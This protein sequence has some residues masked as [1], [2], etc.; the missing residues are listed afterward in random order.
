LT[1]ERHQKEIAAG[2]RSE[3]SR[4]FYKWDAGLDV[5]NGLILE[6]RILFPASELRA[7]REA[8]DTDDSIFWIPAL[9]EDG[10]AVEVSLFTAPG[11]PFAEGQ[12]PAQRRMGTLVIGQGH[13]SDGRR[14]WL[15]FRYCQSP[16]LSKLAELAAQEMD[17]LGIDPAQLT[18]G[19]R[20]KFPFKSHDE[21]FGFLEMAADS[22]NA[23]S[24]AMGHKK[25]PAG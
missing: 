22:F 11:G 24:S 3:K 8:D 12:W 15:L 4:M 21:T 9:V 18:S 1:K 6:F 14:F 16:P 19:A 2:R 20:A 23:K 5:A 13:L 25:S 17:R 10:E 7:F